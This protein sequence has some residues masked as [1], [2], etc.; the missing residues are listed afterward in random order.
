MQREFCATHR[1]HRDTIE[2]IRDLRRQLA[3]VCKAQF[4]LSD[5]ESTNLISDELP[6]PSAAEEI[7]LRQIL[8]T[9]FCDSIARRAPAGSIPIGTRRKRLTAYFSC[10]PS[11]KVP[12]YI[13][14]ESS[15]YNTDPTASL[16]EY[17]VYNDLLMNSAGDVTYMV[18]VT[19]IHQNWISQLTRDCPLLQWSAPLIS[20]AP[21]FES[22]K[23]KIMCY[24]VPKYGSEKWELPPVKISLETLQ[25]FLNPNASA[26]FEG[27]LIG[28]RS[29]DEHA[30]WFV[31]LLLEGNILTELKM[32]LRSEFLKIRPTA[33][34]QKQP[35]ALISSILQQIIALNIRTKRDLISHIKDGIKK[36]KKDKDTISSKHLFLCEELQ[37]FLSSEHRKKFREVYKRTCFSFQS[38]NIGKG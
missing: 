20:P 1:L 6:P 27:Q 35:N 38:T 5:D 25:S 19:E 12:L 8:M 28:Y 21:Y 31:R 9:G 36:S 22:K 14:P 30:R 11:I 13:H 3:I 34:T 24:S 37:Q 33:V 32:V 15:L 18:C 7:A 10:D 16:P 2:K 23:D 4:E 29:I 26:K 17:L